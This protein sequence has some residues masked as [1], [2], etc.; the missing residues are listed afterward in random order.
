MPVHDTISQASLAT[1]VGL[2][3]AGILVGVQ[4]PNPPARKSSLV[5]DSLRP[6]VD[7]HHN[8]FYLYKFLIS[9]VALHHIALI[10]TYPDSPPSLLRHATTNGLQRCHVTW[11]KETAI[12]IALILCVGAPLRV[13][14]YGA[15]GKNFTFNLSAPSRLT[16]SGLYRYMQHPSYTGIMALMIGMV[17]LWGRVDGI[18]SCAIPPWLYPTLRRLEWA[19]LFLP[20]AMLVSA[21]FRRVKEEEQLLRQHFGSEWEA[22]HSRTARF[23]PYVF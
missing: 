9:G 7:F 13:M 23:I 18:L 17:G 11:S 3:T 8:Y 5:H 21:V 22:W 12:P 2:S 6:Y 16:T 20:V 14:S 15:L 10:L 4:P 1:A 19:S